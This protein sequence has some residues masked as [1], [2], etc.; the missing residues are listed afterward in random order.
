MPI[1]SGRARHR[2]A[3]ALLLAS[4]ALIAAC[5]PPGS[6]TGASASAGSGASQPSAA[7]RSVEPRPS[8]PTPQPSFVA[9][10]PTPAPTFTVVQ[11]RTGDTLSSIARR[12]STTARSI[13]FW[14]RATYPSLDPD[15]TKYRPD[16]LE[17][18]WMLVLIPHVELTDEEAPPLLTQPPSLEPSASAGEDAA[19]GASDEA[20]AQAP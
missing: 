19:D 3:V 5:L 2:G 17:I 11:V 10:T 12:F 6:R 8:G 16:R 18:G 9:P 14:N 15:S 7:V 1:S 4:T 13:S 20:S